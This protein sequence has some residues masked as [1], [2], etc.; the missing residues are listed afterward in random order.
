MKILVVDDNREFC[1]NAKD[2]LELY[3]HTVITVY[4]GVEA[5]DMIKQDTPDFVLMDVVMP[6]M[7]GV[8]ALK[9]MKKMVP[10]LPVVLVSGFSDEGLGGEARLAGAI[11]LLG[12]PLDF[13]KFLK[14]AKTSRRC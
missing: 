11:S 10:Q 13:E 1:E 4:D 6:G 9:E 8:A 14:L 12:K 5:L 7:D 3:G 2:V